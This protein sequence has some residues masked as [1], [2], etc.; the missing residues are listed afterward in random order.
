MCTLS[1]AEFVWTIRT[2]PDWAAAGVA[3]AT[4]SERARARKPGTGWNRRFIATSGV[5]DNLTSRYD[6]THSAVQQL[7]NTTRGI[8]AAMHPRWAEL[9]TVQTVASALQT[10]VFSLHSRPQGSAQPSHSASMIA[11]ANA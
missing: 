8:R 10:V 5:R 4:G 6:P 11:L 7:V 1:P 3:G 9:S 2:L